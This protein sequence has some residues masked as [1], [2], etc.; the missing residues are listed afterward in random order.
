MI[1]TT[2]ELKC[3]LCDGGG[4]SHLYRTPVFRINDRQGYEV[5][6]VPS[7]WMACEGCHPLIKELRN[8]ELLERV[9]KARE[10]VGENAGAAGSTALPLRES[11]A[12]FPTA[13]VRRH[14]D[15][16]DTTLAGEGITCTACDREIPE[17]GTALVHWDKNGT[18]VGVCNK[19]CAGVWG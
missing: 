5:V 14:C 11:G 13:P 1:D 4:V 15:M 18:P 8:D 19:T 2:V 12:R 16:R 6:P 7:R 10:Q 9:F 3:D 17:G